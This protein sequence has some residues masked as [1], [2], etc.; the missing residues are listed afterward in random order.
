M[1]SSSPNTPVSSGVK[2]TLLWLMRSTARP[3]RQG[4][5]GAASRHENPF[6]KEGPGMVDGMQDDCE[7]LGKGRLVDR[8]PVGDLVALPGFS[9]K[10]LTKRSLNVRHWHCTAIKAH[11]Q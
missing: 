4:A 9:D 8:D 10:A 7:G 5:N 6:A 2:S 3:G 1:A 11:V